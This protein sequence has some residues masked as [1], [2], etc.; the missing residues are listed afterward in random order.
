MKE[1]LIKYWLEFL[2]GLAITGLTFCVN[3]IRN[4]MKEQ[5]TVKEGMVALLHDRLF[6]SGMYYLDKGE[7]SVLELQNFEDLY[8]AYHKLGGNGTG[9]EIYERVLDLELKK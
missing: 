9:T 3:H 7:I 5:E 6:Q 8:N 4:K 1:F 2:F